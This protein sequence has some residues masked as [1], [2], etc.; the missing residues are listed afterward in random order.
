MPQQLLTPPHALRDHLRSLA[1]DRFVLALGQIL[2]GNHHYGD[3]RQAGIRAHILQQIEAVAA[4]KQEVQHNCVYGRHIEDALRF[5]GVGRGQR[6]VAFI[7]QGIRQQFPRLGIVIDNQDAQGP[8]RLQYAA[9]G[10]K[11]RL[12]GERLSQ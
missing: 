7:H 3:A 10:L 5:D 4:G 9:H 2:D 8:F 6:C 12:R 1:R 11:Q